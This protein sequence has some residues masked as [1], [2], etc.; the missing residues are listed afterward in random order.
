MPWS[1]LSL[2]EQSPISP[3]TSTS[4]FPNTVNGADVVRCGLG[5]VL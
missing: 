4:R 3:E 5:F 1:Y 2:K